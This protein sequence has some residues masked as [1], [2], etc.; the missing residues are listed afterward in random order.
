MSNKSRRR[1]TVAGAILAAAAIPTAAAA[2]AWADIDISYDGKTII[3]TFPSGETPDVVSGTD[4]DLAIASGPASAGSTL[5]AVDDSAGDQN[6]VA[7]ASGAGSDA[8]IFDASDS[9]AT[10]ENGGQAIIN[11]EAFAL[12]VTTVDTHDLVV[13]NGT[14]SVANIEVASDSAAIAENG[15]A[16]TINDNFPAIEAIKA[17]GGVPD[18]KDL[19]VAIGTDSAA[20]IQE[21]SDSSNLVT[22]GMSYTV[23]E[24]G[25]NLFNDMPVDA[26][27][28]LEA[29]TDAYTAF[30][31]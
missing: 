18:T 14:G 21:A 8:T 28:A 3:D 10:A 15:G 12:D 17:G 16:A 27:P 19:A 4:N 30:L 2:I 23:T 6:D 31:P 22:D 11:N 26:S 1:L 20:R 7:S 9:S 24:S 25:V 13:A 29:F 5:I